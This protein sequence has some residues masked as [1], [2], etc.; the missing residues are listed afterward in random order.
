MCS[1]VEVDYDKVDF[2]APRWFMDYSWSE[3][4]ERKFTK[5]LSNYLY[6]SKEA[7]IELMGYAYKNKARCIQAA[8]EFNWYTW[9][10]SPPVF[11]K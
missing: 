4:Q 7:R 8:E 1:R 6:N 5:W 10:I 9:T 3:E 11:P 2:K